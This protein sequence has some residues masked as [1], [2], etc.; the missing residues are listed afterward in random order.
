[1]V[2]ETIKDAG[3][4]LRNS[5]APRSHHLFSGLVRCTLPLFKNFG[6]DK[7]PYLIF[8][9]YSIMNADSFDVFKVSKRCL[10][11]KLDEQHY[12]ISKNF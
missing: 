11:A 10:N 12:A 5:F 4:I 1:L 3:N 2:L 8:P 7:K 6:I 9:D